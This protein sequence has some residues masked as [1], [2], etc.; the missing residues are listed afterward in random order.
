L[1]HTCYHWVGK[2]SFARQLE[3]LS[4][5][6]FRPSILPPPPAGICANRHVLS[7]LECC[8][9]GWYDPLCGQRADPALPHPELITFLGRY[10]ESSTPSR[11]SLE[12]STPADHPLLADAGVA[13]SGADQDDLP[14]VEG[15]RHSQPQWRHTRPGHHSGRGAARSEQRLDVRQAI[16][17]YPAAIFWCLAVSM[18]VIMEGYDTIL[19]GNFF[20]FPT[21]QR[22]CKYQ[23]PSCLCP[24]GIS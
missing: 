23:A 12:E 18:C 9:N 6:P 17:A 5:L 16:R 15:E 2:H 20:A 7:Q 19:I 8:H 3:N 11:T 24:W 4:S 21:F 13:L 1:G 10:S 14:P 22:K